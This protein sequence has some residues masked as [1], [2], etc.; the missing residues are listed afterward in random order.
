V[1]LKIR[2]AL[3]FRHGVPVSFWHMGH[4]ADRIVSF[5]DGNGIVESFPQKPVTGLRLVRRCHLE[6]IQRANGSPAG[7]RE[8][9][10][11]VNA[12]IDEKRVI[13]VTGTKV[14]AQQRQD[15]IF[16]LNLAAQNPA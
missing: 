14:R 12:V 8:Q 9:D 7:H 3:K 6:M 4:P 13:G 11:F 5:P 2:I 15:M 1:S 16:W 10:I